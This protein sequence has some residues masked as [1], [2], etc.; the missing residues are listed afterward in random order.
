M[1]ALP[2]GLGIVFSEICIFLNTWCLYV[3]LLYL[4]GLVSYDT[5]PIMFMVWP[6]LCNTW[7]EAHDS[8]VKSLIVKTEGSSPREDILGTHWYVEKS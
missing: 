3:P 8:L 7:N 2:L 4:K 5:A 6:P 1:H